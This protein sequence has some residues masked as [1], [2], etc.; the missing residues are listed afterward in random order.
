MIVFDFFTGETRRVALAQRERLRKQL[1]AR[2]LEDYLD[3]PQQMFVFTDGGRIAGIAN[4]EQVMQ[5]EMDHLCFLLGPEMFRRARDYFH[6]HP[7][8]DQM[9]YVIDRKCQ[10]VGSVRYR[11]NYIGTGWQIPE[12]Y[13]EYDFE[14]DGVNEDLLNKA[15]GYVFQTVEEYSYAIAMYLSK[16]HPER[17]IYFL[18]P[19]ERWG[20][21]SPLWTGS[22]VHF[23][24]LLSDL[25]A[26]KKWLYIDSQM[27]DNDTWLPE[28]FLLMHTS[29][30]VMF[31][32]LWGTHPQHLG[33][34]FPDKKI[35]LV[36][37]SCSA[38][39][40]DIIYSVCGC[41]T[42][43]ERKGY[44]PVIDLSGKDCCSYWEEGINV[45]GELF[46]PWSDEVS[47]AQARQSSHVIQASKELGWWTG[48]WRWNPYHNESL[49]YSNRA[50]YMCEKTKL[51]DKTW[52]Y[53]LAHAPAELIPRLEQEA[54]VETDG[55]IGNAAAPR[56]GGAFLAS[57]FV[58]RTIA[59]KQ[60]NLPLIR[61][62]TGA[63]A[64]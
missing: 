51:N 3:R 29:L 9:F 1:Q 39:L 16:H 40:V 52:R 61:W 22:H 18:D 41:A 42:Y 12:D 11:K 43:L 24:R 46:Q 27:Q 58:A 19:D 4:E 31:S 63:A 5:G 23:A 56:G 48:T 15:D 32:M 14:R 10:V 62:W 47:V 64:C 37:L 30:R 6:E 44:I 7:R 60:A 28:S 8:T 36:D 59:G 54:A 2:R 26:G 53:V 55:R 25:P 38:G 35:G 13:W 21:L 20:A 34:L 50:D 17:D 49:Y 57:S 45:W 33:P